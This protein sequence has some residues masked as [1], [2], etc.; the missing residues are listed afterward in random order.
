[1]ILRAA[2]ILLAACAAG[3]V[4]GNGTQQPKMPCTQFVSYG[5]GVT[6]TVLEEFGSLTTVGRSQKTWERILYG[7]QESSKRALRTPQGLATDGHYIWVCDQGFPDVF[8]VD[9]Q[10]GNIRSATARTHRPASPIALARDDSGNLYVADATRRAVLVFGPDGRL[11]Y[12]L[13][14]DA[15]GQPFEPTALLVR[16]QQLFIADRSHCQISR[17]DLATRTWNAPLA[18]PPESDGLAVPTG[19]AMTQ[20]GVLLIA[21]AMLGVIHRVDAQG[22]WLA[23]IAQRGRG[24]GQLV[25]PIGVCCTPSGLIAVADAARQSV[26][27]FDGDGT[28]LIDLSG[29]DN[30]WRGWT[31]PMGVACLSEKPGV[32][33]LATDQGEVQSEWIVVSDMLGGSGLTLIGIATDRPRI[34]AS[35]TEER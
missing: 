31:L 29:G 11:Q 28:H 20:D 34:A 17:Y 10:S 3:C 12:E 27:I 25:R 19:L 33:G 14:A 24:T 7:P 21:D 5:K 8:Q 4:S 18:P 26:A 23:P 2:P 1:M 16:N 35:Q 6:A 22:T 9:P 32:A 13:A 30:G 15:S